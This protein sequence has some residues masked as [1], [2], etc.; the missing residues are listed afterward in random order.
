MARRGPQ[1]AQ[2]DNVPVAVD[3]VLA[4]V[5]QQIGGLRR[6]GVGIEL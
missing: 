1:V 4:A 3:E 2:R 5:D 6:L